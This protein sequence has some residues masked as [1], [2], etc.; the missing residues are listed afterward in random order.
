MRNSKEEAP[1]PEES[2]PEALERIGNAFWECSHEDPCMK[3]L[4]DELHGLIEQVIAANDGEGLREAAYVLQSSQLGAEEFP[5]LNFEFILS[6]LKRPDFLEMEGSYHLLGIFDYEAK[7]LSASQK[8]R[9]IEALEEAYPQFHDWM[10]CFSI[11]E[12][13]EELL[14]SEQG[15]RMFCRL[16]KIEREM[17]RS[18]LPHGLEH[19]ITDSQDRALAADAMAQF[20][21]FRSDPSEQV[22]SEVATSLRRIVVKG[23]DG[24]SGAAL[25]ALAEMK[26]DTSGNVREFVTSSLKWL[27]D[28]GHVLTNRNSP[29]R[30][31]G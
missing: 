31:K 10:S 30:L 1:E 16:S 27:E 24:F 15:F 26:N 7:K 14:N 12:F 3:P 20:L 5:T 6:L 8:E 2:F 18:F 25:K 21:S 28:K 29:S 4:M 19:L 23:S 11:T 17:P 9:L 22:R 13:A